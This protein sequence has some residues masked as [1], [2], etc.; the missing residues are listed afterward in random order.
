MAR[1]KLTQSVYSPFPNGGANCTTAHVYQA[2][3]STKQRQ[4]AIMESKRGSGTLI[5]RLQMSTSA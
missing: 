3:E 4:A 5:A 2:L 1:E